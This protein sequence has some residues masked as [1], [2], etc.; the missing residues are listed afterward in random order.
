MKLTRHGSSDLYDFMETSRL[1]IDE[2]EVYVWPH[3]WSFPYGK[4]PCLSAKKI[5]KRAIFHCKAW[6]YQRVTGSPSYQSSPAEIAL[7]AT[8]A[9]CPSLLTRKYPLGRQLWLARLQRRYRPLP[10]RGVAT[11]FTSLA[12]PALNN[13]STHTKVFIGNSKVVRK[14]WKR[15]L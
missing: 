9:R 5:Y 3:I 13:Y 2:L 11:L 8:S 1:F 12:S 4:S 7:L 15:T 6:K 10:P 14:Y